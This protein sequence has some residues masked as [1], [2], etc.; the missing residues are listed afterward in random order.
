MLVFGIFPVPLDGV[1][2]SWRSS[3]N[4]LYPGDNELL[5]TVRQVSNVLNSININKEVADPEF[6]GRGAQFVRNKGEDN[7]WMSYEPI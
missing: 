5:A 2:T 1:W 6:G 3:Y 7:A 4:S